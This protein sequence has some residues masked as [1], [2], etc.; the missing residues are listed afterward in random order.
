MINSLITWS[1]KCQVHWWLLITTKFSKILWTL[2]RR[3]PKP[4]TVDINIHRVDGRLEAWQG[5]L[6][7][8]KLSTIAMQLGSA[9]ALPQISDISGYFHVPLDS[10]STTS[11]FHSGSTMHR[12]IRSSTHSPT[13]PLIHPPIH[14]LTHQY[15]LRSLQDNKQNNKQ[16]RTTDKLGLREIKPRQRPPA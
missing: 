16:Q 10:T 3:L 7:L 9:N 11:S 15:I 5:E 14:P 1:P 2:S 4:T 8:R 6:A 12:I 13:H